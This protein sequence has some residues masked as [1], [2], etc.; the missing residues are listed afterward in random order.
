MSKKGKNKGGRPT[1]MTP[2]TIRKLEEA[3]ALGC[4]DLEACLFADIGKSTLYDYQDENPE[5][6]ER[7]ARL[8]ENPV[9]LAR[10]SVVEALEGDPD[11]ALKFLER[12]KKDEFSVKQVQEHSGKIQINIDDTDS[13]L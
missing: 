3:F 6:A 4:T 7:K 10:K 5:F 2:D 13:K 1:K 11:L 8:K 12:K 9:L